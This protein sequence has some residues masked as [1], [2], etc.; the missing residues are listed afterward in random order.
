MTDP[1]VTLEAYIVTPGAVLNA[2][3]DAAAG[4]AAARFV[5]Q[6]LF[7]SIIEIGRRPRRCMFGCGERMSEVR[8]ERAPAA[9][10]VLIPM[11][12]H[13]GPRTDTAI[14][15]PICRD[16]FD[17]PGLL[18]RLKEVLATDYECTVREAVKQ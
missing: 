4:D 16:C 11:F 7:E 13:T 6:A 18:R 1:L 14:S 12:P 15:S 8:G 17:Q 10:C 2:A 3:L 9:F 5:I